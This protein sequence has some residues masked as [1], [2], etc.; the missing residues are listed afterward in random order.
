[1]RR[2]ALVLFAL[3]AALWAGADLGF[4][5][6][7][8]DAGLTYLDLARLVCPD[9]Q[10]NPEDHSRGILTQT[11]PVRSFW[12]KQASES[13]DGPLDGLEELEILRPGT[14]QRLLAMTF[15]EPGN[16]YGHVALALFDLKPEAHLLDIAEAPGFPDDSGGTSG[17]LNLGPNGEAIIFTAYHHN[18]SQGY[19]SSSLL[20][21]DDAK[22][23]L[24]YQA[25]IMNARGCEGGTFEQRL[26]FSS[27][28]D[29]G[30][31]FYKVLVEVS[32]LLQPDDENCEK[33]VRR[34]AGFKVYRGVF[35]F[36]M[37][38]R[39]YVVLSPGLEELDKLNQRD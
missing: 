25:G 38:S 24:I 9:L 10:V 19:Q 27:W 13:W 37:G 14:S 8:Q 3:P 17:T 23:K 30:R 1:M 22:I 28:P 21:V 12:G 20:Y 11:V 33:I 4:Q 29:P 18:S 2:V 7:G 16:R 26:K 35:R 39:K 31:D 34:K 15:R 32:V 5:V 6:S 36:Q